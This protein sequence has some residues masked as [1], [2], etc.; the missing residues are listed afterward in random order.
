MNGTSVNR[1][2]QTFRPLALLGIVGLLLT[3]A[4]GCVS[5]RAHI[6]VMPN[7]ELHVDERADILP[8]VVDS[9]GLDPKLAW[10]AFEATTQA[11]GGKFTKDRPDSLTGA[12]ATYPLDNWAE[13]GQRGQ[14]FKGIDE[15]ERRTRP[16]NLQSEVQDQYFWTVTTLSYELEMSEPSS[17]Q[18]DSIWLPWLSQARGELVLEVPGTIVETNAT[19]REGNTLTYPLAYGETVEVM[20]SF[21][22]MQWVAVV[23]VILVAIFLIY[24]LL[25]G[26]KGMK[27]RGKKQPPHPKTA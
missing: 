19:N 27:A 6:T 14:A 5:Y 7:G 16:A 1:T 25:A 10:T 24:L 13:L 17:A 15:I 22:Q 12:S 20:V 4:S 26:L 9:M 8:G 18:V 21:K 23:S 3:I 2:R 11:R